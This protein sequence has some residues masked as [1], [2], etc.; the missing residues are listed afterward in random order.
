MK[1]EAAIV[2]MVDFAAASRRVLEGS[3]E[4][5]EGNDPLD[6]LRHQLRRF[7]PESAICRTDASAAD[8]RQA[9][10]DIEDGRADT[11]LIADSAGA[12]ALQ[13]RT[14]ARQNNETC[15]AIISVAPEPDG[16]PELFQ[17][18]VAICETIQTTALS[19]FYRFLPSGFGRAS[20]R[21]WFSTGVRQAVI[22][23]AGDEPFALSESGEIRQL[24][25]TTLRIRSLKLIPVSGDTVEELQREAAA[26]AAR[27][28][29]GEP[30]EA[31]AHAAQMCCRDTGRH[32]LGLSLVARTNADLM[33]EL[34][35]FARGV[36]KTVASGEEWKTPAGSCFAPNPL[37]GSGV[38]FVYPGVGSP[39]PGAGADLFGIA[40]HLMDEFDRMTCGRSARYLHVDE[41][42][43]RQPLSRA[44]FGLTDVIGLG[45][46]AMS[47]SSIMTMLM[48]DCFGIAP[49]SAF[50]YSFGEAIMVAALR[51]WRSPI[52]LTERL[53][54]SPAF[55]SRLQGRMNAIREAWDLPALAPLSWRSSTVRA[56]PG[57][58]W[59][60]LRQESRAYLCMVNSPEQVVIAG[61]EEACSRALGRL[62]SAAVPMP[63][64][65]TM[66]CPPSRSE[67]EELVRIHDL[68]TVGDAGPSLYFSANY[69]AVL[70]NRTAVARAI[71]EG[72]TNTVDFPR[73][74]RRVY[75][76]GARVFL[77][78]GSRRNCCTWIEKILQGRP[79]A[80]IA[81]DSEGLGGEAAIV[82]AIARLFA[83]RVPLKL[84]AFE[85]PLKAD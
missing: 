34:D 19:L 80:A 26:I 17:A 77:E 9:I 39:Y 44:A 24:P 76:D 54:S 73:L 66:H 38:A 53:D 35:L 30:L 23:I 68:E 62:K 79:H 18:A 59:A 11:V 82:R 67:L 42:Y 16:E 46:C 15:Y 47:I 21:P 1:R 4:L 63:I 51:I 83:H 56:T 22:E 71:A 60:A 6:A 64:A 5:F 72:Y 61:D 49:R 28:Q 33:R 27:A 50:G 10:R 41:L 78:L 65:V 25:V 70:P 14:C 43:P 55:R 58:A 45:E 31:I 20:R 2:A 48:R 32:C 7:D 8:V 74:V 84:D 57:E 81:C 75:A 52:T 40:P 12:I 36:P 37:G 3:R 85:S 69:T 29:Q 13:E